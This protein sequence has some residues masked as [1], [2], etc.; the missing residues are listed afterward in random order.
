VNVLAIGA[1]ASEILLV[2]GGTLAKYALAGHLV[3][4]AVTCR[5]GT[6]YPEYTQET[7]EADARE[8][9]DAA[10]VISARTY[11]LQLPQ[12]G[13][14]PDYET[15]LKVVE[16]IRQVQPDLIITHDRTDYTMDHRMISEI[17]TDCVH[18]SKQAG[19][20]TGSAPV[21]EHPDVVFMDTTAGV[22]FEPDQ[23][24]DITKVIDVKRRIV[25]AFT[26]EVEDFKDNPVVETLEW[27]EV[28]ARYRG[29]QSGYRY[30]E[31]FRWPHRWGFS[32]GQPML[33]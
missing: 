13:L 28:T 10:A 2:C 9:R 24:V 4:I 6:R 32:P 11:D 29:I 23:Y 19:I 3:S 7:A 31:A 33:I 22:A 30:A 1:Y 14:R 18:M 12:F 8:L 15:K 17:V 27:V 5:T 21:T 26:R 25:A 20:K 16:V